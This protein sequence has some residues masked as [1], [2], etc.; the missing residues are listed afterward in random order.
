[1]HALIG[2]IGLVKLATNSLLF[3]WISEIQDGWTYCPVIE[4]IKLLLYCWIIGCF[5]TTYVTFKC[6]KYKNSFK[7]F[8]GSFWHQNSI[9]RNLFVTS[10]YMEI[11]KAYYVIWSSVIEIPLLVFEPFLQLIFWKQPS[12]HALYIFIINISICHKDPID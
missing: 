10:I 5:L 11:L 4:A 8:C 7:S 12:G 2:V 1:M 6:K 3:N 9:A